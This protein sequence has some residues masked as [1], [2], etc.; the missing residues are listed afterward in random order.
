MKL[1]HWSKNSNCCSPCW[2]MLFFRSEAYETYTLFRWKTTWGRHTNV[3][4]EQ[5]RLSFCHT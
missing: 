3:Y 2:S 1:Q 4:N 5:I